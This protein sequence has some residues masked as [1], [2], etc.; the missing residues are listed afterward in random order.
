MARPIRSRILWLVM[1]DA[2]QGEG[3]M[4]MYENAFNSIEKHLRS[5][6][7]VA[8]ELDYVEQT[9]WVLFF[10]YLDDYENERRDLANLDGLP[11]API[12]QGDLMAPIKLIGLA[13]VEAERHIG[14]RRCLL[15]RLRPTGRIAPYR[16]IAT[17]ITSVAQFFVNPNQRQALPLGLPVIFGQHLIQIGSPGVNLGERLRRAVIAKL[18]CPRSHHLTHRVPRHPQLPANLLDRLPLDKI[19]P[20]DLRN[21]L[22]DH[23]PQLAPSNPSRKLLNRIIRGALLDADYPNTGVNFACRFTITGLRLI[24]GGGRAEVEAAHIRAVE[25]DG[26]D[27]VSNGIAL[28]GTAHWMF[29]RGL[30][31]LSDDLDILVSRQANDPDAIRSMINDSGKLIA[32]GRLAERP[33]VEFVQWHR[34][35]YFKDQNGFQS[36]TSYL[37]NLLT[38]RLKVRHASNSGSSVVLHRVSQ[39]MKNDLL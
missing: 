20:P 19:R 32:P 10:K 25:H 23:H 31:G 24:N 2:N 9:S 34:T 29:D 39:D 18:G 36:K 21:R 1:E 15:G 13:R 28:S 8:N 4:Y 12:I 17:V 38:H 37:Q 22:H 30:V 5:E 11:Y 16:V 6:E 26:P 35:E 14:R 33:R 3:A 27:I 7:D